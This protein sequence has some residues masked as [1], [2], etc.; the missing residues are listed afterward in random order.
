MIS[1]IFITRRT[2][3]DDYVMILAWI[4]AFGG[5][6]T[7]LLAARKGLG[8]MDAELKPE[9]IT[10][11]KKCGYIYSIIYVCIFLL[12]IAWTSSSAEQEW[13]GI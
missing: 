5:S 10:T 13:S 1:R 4:I 2:T 11:L 12:I 9:W 8:L 7:I 3:L 6:F